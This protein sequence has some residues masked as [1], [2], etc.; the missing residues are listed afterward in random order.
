MLEILGR[1]RFWALYDTLDERSSALTDY[2]LLLGESGRGSNGLGRRA[3]VIF[4]R[5]KQL[6]RR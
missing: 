5:A 4:D 6:I 3:R 2:R 1:E